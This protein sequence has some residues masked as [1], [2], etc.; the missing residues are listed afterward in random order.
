MAGAADHIASVTEPMLFQGADMSTKLK[1]LGVDVA[2]I[3]DA[4]ACTEGAKCFA[5]NDEISGVY[6]RVVVDAEAKKLLGVVLVGNAELAACCRKW[7]RTDGHSGGSS[8]A[9][10]RR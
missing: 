6:K 5:Y 1:L 2:S 8:C 7:R 4:H 3:G 10:C 9:S